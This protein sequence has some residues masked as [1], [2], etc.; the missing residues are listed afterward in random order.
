MNLPESETVL[1]R[2]KAITPWKIRLAHVAML[3]SRS[4]YKAQSYAWMDHKGPSVE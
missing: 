4:V 1:I 3:T 2:R